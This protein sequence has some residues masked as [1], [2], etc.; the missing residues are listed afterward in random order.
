ME[1]TKNGE[2]TIKEKKNAYFEAIDDFL[3][4]TFVSLTALIASRT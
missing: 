4:I 2:G 1:E 3:Y